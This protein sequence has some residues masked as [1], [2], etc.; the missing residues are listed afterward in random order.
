M[1]PLCTKKRYHLHCSLDGSTGVGFAN[2]QV[3]YT[4][5]VKVASPK[6]ESISKF[7]PQTNPCCK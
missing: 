4:P 3:G 1:Y 7:D 2:Y 5:L 6:K